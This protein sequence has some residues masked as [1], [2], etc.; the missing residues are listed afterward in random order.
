MEE[1]I[2]KRIKHYRAA[3]GW[4][5]AKFAQQAGVAQVTISRLETGR[6]GVNIG[7]AVAQRIEQ[8]LNDNRR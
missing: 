5:Q 4:S 3:R 8:V 7:H 2:G 1:A 6:R